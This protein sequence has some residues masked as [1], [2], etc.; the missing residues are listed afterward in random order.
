MLS[1]DG[2][3]FSTE[4]RIVDKNNSDRVPVPQTSLRRFYETLLLMQTTKLRK[5]MAN[6]LSKESGKKERIGKISKMI[7]QSV[8]HVSRYINANEGFHPDRGAKHKIDKFLDDR[9]EFAKCLQARL[10]AERKITTELSENI[11]FIDYEINPLR[12]TN[13]AVND[14][15]RV[16]TSGYGGL[17]LLLVEQ[18][19][20]KQILIVGEVKAKTDTDLFLAFFQS[21]VY[22][23]ELGTENQFE[24]LRSQSENK[25]KL[26]GLDLATGLDIYLI[27]ETHPDDVKLYKQTLRICELL[28]QHGNLVKKI[29]RKVKFVQA[30]LEEDG[31]VTLQTHHVVESANHVA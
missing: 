10:R 11:G 15:G 19:L 16:G 20:E 27:F 28:L 26:Q 24:R 8:G 21:L 14:D 18:S 2:E 4:P 12:A 7:D 13:H 30:N 17:D 22:A 23:V 5:S 29:I 3:D 6:Y 9:N 1:D 31:M 25:S